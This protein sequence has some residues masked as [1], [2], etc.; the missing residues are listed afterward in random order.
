MANIVELFEKESPR[1]FRKRWFIPGIAMLWR[2]KY[3]R[4]TLDDVLQQYVPRLTLGE[5]A[6]PLLITSADLVT[7]GVH[8]FKS[9]YLAQLG[10][11]YERDGEVFLRDAILASCA[12]PT[13]F[14]PKQVQ[15]HLLV[16]GSLW[17]NNPSIIALTEAL[18][19]FNRTIEDVRV[20]SIGTGHAPNMYHRR[21]S[22]GLLTG[23]GREK[24][25]S[26][27]LGLQSQAF[28]NMARLILG[29]RYFRLDPTTEDWQ[30]DDTRRLGNL[31]ALADRDFARESRA[32]LAHIAG[33]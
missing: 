21:R 18:S 31:K 24:L 19:K 26:Y 6:T 23:W 11:P 16:D 27:T 2:S 7:G 9:A 17:A 12:A 8:V 3:S 14:D 5:V 15:S 10:E 33:D 32:I 1:I 4:R 13:F 25:I 30:L 28:T 20:L 22:W 29:P